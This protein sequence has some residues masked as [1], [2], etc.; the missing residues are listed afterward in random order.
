MP[1]LESLTQKNI[2]LAKKVDSGA[3]GGKS[4][5]IRMPD[6][7]IMAHLAVMLSL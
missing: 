4:F 3:S 6:P 2:E 7:I 1:R 5:T